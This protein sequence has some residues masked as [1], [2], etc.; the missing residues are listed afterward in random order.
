MNF[1]HFGYIVDCLGQNQLLLTGLFFLVSNKII[2]SMLNYHFVLRFIPEY[3]KLQ[4][5]RKTQVSSF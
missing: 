5:A 1:N 2:K 4:K 3:H